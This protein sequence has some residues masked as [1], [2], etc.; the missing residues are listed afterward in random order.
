MWFGGLAW[1]PE[2]DL[3]QVWGSEKT[4]FKLDHT[5]LWHH[6]MWQVT[7]FQGLE[8]AGKHEKSGKC[9]EC[10]ISL[11]RETHDVSSL[12]AFH[13]LISPCVENFWSQWLM[14]PLTL[15]QM[16]DSV[17]I[18]HLLLKYHIVPVLSPNVCNIIVFQTPVNLSPF[19]WATMAVWTTGFAHIFTHALLE[20]P[21]MK[22]WEGLK[23]TTF[24][25]SNVDFVSCILHHICLISDLPP[26]LP[27]CMI[28]K[29][30]YIPIFFLEFRL[31]NYIGG[32]LSTKCTGEK[33]NSWR[34]WIHVD[35]VNWSMCISDVLTS[36]WTWPC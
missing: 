33:S 21:H 6:Y 13:F 30:K 5:R 11:G 1:E 12:L 23:F 18:L 34:F 20:H 31:V 10:T 35:V 3:D 16:V 27:E 32:S 7:G 28:F 17:C 29:Q 26:I 22:M 36:C 4:V 19:L 15:D 2:P 9:S 8:T 14:F 25:A 24:N